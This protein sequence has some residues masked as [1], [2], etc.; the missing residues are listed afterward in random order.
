MSKKVSVDFARRIK[1]LPPYLFAVIDQMKAA[2]L[3]KGV[4]L[5]DMSIGDPDIPT[6]KHIVESMRKAV[7][8]PEHH[9]YPSYV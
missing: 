1:K 4:D 6:P 3:K 9:K 7:R 8:N 5:I 2:A